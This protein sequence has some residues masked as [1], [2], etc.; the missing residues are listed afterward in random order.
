VFVAAGVRAQA[1]QE[2]FVTVFGAKI[3]Y[4]EAGDPAKPTVILLHGLGGSGDTSWMFTAP[5]LAANYY[6]ITPDQIGFGKSDKPFLNYRVATY[7][8]FLDKFMS[9]LKIEKATLVGNSMGGWVSVLFAEKRPAKVEKLVLVDSAGYAPPKGF[10]YGQL[11]RLNPSTRDGVRAMVKQL[12]FNSALFS[13]DAA[14]DQFMAARVAAN[15]GYT[16]QTLIRNIETGDDYFDTQVRAV[17]HPTLIVWGK[18]DGL[19]P[20]SDGERLSR[21]IAGSELAVFDQAGHFPQMEKAADFNK[22]VSEFLAK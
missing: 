17:K 14:I 13:T 11:Q 10:D 1:V 7:V 15:D 5:A 22:R 12:F 16:I 6:V 9:E 3:R 21:D 18:Q 19:A 4:T 20:V 8:D 2:K